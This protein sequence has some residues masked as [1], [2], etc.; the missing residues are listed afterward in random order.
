MVNNLGFVGHTICI[1]IGQFLLI[2]EAGIDKNVFMNK[3]IYE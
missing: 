3:L 2:S 1:A